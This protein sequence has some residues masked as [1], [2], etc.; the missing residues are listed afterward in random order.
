MT[1]VVIFSFVAY[2]ATLFITAW[3]MA[4]TCW[5][6]QR[7]QADLESVLLGLAPRPAQEVILRQAG[8][9]GP[10]GSGDMTVEQRMDSQAI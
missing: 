8:P 2:L 9:L 7:R 4:K 10:M 3:F 5:E 1:L 6:A